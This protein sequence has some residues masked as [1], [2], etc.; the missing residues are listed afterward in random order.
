MSKFSR[1]GLFENLLGS[2]LDNLAINAGLDE[3]TSILT[4][5]QLMHLLRRATFGMSIDT[6]NKYSGKKAG[7]IVDDLFA[8]ADRKTNPT[9]PFFVN[10]T[11][12][13]PVTLTGKQKDDENARV[14]KHKDEYNWTLGEWWVRLMKVDNESVLEKLVLFWHDHFATQYASCD[15]MAAT[16]MYNQN[17]FLRK[18]YAGSFRT[19]LEGICIDGAMLFYLNG[20]ENIAESPNENFARELMELF[21]LGVGNYT[22]NDIREAAKILTGW[23]VSMFSNEA[24]KPYKAFLVP[25][26]FDKNNKQFMGENFPVNYE[27]N[28]A[29]VNENSVKKLIKTI[30]TKKS[31][32]AAKF[33]SK[34]LYEYYFYSN[35]SKNSQEF[36]DKMANKLL[37]NN[38]SLRPLL[39][40]MFKSQHFFEDVIIGSQIKSPAESIVGMV[41]HLNY[42]DLYARNI[43][44]ELGLELFNPPN[45]AG[46]KG[47]RGWVNTVSLPSTINF[48]KIIINNSNNQQL[49]QWGTGFKKYDDIDVFVTSIMELFLV[50]STPA[51]R[52][53]KYKNVVLAGAP[54]YEWLVI[55]KNNDSFGQRL[56]NLLFEIIKSPDYFLF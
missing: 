54:E 4:R 6:I 39:V 36:I 38:F 55:V 43:M 35:S 11:F 40:A 49:G 19:L 37:E 45:V 44:S 24:E 34:K 17:D 21:S 12:K 53:K 41:R 30:L 23:N 27:I 52:L 7:E 13:N 50:Q 56:R 9:Q 28:A 26:R 16:F 51:D 25:D 14:K 33:I 22:E 10:E 1:R 31:E 5:P 47:Y 15:N 46:W 8:N 20:K 29:N 32:V 48:L 18:N 42:P 3:Y 2:P